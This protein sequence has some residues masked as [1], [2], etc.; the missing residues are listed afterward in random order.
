MKS[1]AKSLPSEKGWALCLEGSSKHRE[2]LAA[3][4][5]WISSIALHTLCMENET[6]EAILSILGAALGNTLNYSG[7]FQSCN[8]IIEDQLALFKKLSICVS[9]GK[10]LTAI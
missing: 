10:H 5:T 7:Y 8:M 1:I 2:I 6:L 9:V 4:I 3:F